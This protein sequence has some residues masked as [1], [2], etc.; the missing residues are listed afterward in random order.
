MTTT[1]EQAKSKIEVSALGLAIQQSSAIVLLTD[2]NGTI[3]YVNPAFERFYG[4]EKESV[5]GENP[6]VLKS[7]EHHQIFYKKMW[8]TITHGKSWS[9]E[10][11][12][13]RKDHSLVHVLATISPIIDDNG[14]IQYFLGVQHDISERVQ[15]DRDERDIILNIS[16]TMR[17][18]NTRDQLASII[19]N[20][21]C[22][23]L[24]MDAAIVGLREDIGHEEQPLE[25]MRIRIISAAGELA[26]CADKQLSVSKEHIL[27]SILQTGRIYTSSNV[28]ENSRIFHAHE[29]DKIRAAVCLPLTVEGQHIGVLCV[30]NTM[31]ISQRDINTLT[32]LSAMIANA[33]YRQTLHEDLEAQMEALKTAQ[34]QI[35]HAEKLAAMGTLVAGV[36]HELNN[37][38]TSIILYAQMALQHVTDIHLRRDLVQ[39]EQLAF[40]MGKVVRGMLDFVHPDSGNKTYITFSEIIDDVLALLMHEIRLQNITVNVDFSSDLPPIY[41]NKSQLEQVFVNLL[42][43]A[44]QA[45]KGYTDHPKIT[46]RATLDALQDKKKPY[47]HVVFQNNGPHI[48]DTALS[49]IFEPFFTTKR[50]GE[51]T[52]LGLS[53]SYSIIELHGGR[54]WVE[55]IDGSAGV[56]FH[57]HLPVIDD[58]NGLYQTKKPT[59]VTTEPNGNAP[60][61]H[62]LLVD[63]EPSILEV[64]ARI[65]S[66]QGYQVDTAQ[67]S[68]NALE[69]I[70]KGDYD[71]VLCDIQMPD[72]NGV[73]LYYRIQETRP[74][75]LSR[76]IFI[77]GDSVDERT[78]EFIRSVPNRLVN[79]PLG[80]NDL[81]KI[82]SEAVN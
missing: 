1:S 68:T 60:S 7:G 66:K 10:L 55:N 3:L 11:I 36:A 58:R 12:N 81:I 40:R 74:D 28:H 70:Q 6:R 52:G 8:D 23:L 76:L 14:H 67:D 80:I 19:T 38:L 33:L 64:F 17:T 4:Y 69:H 73:E 34:K 48:P 63:D 47:I 54:I 32:A 56:R 35:I 22:D 42:M 45:M 20:Q 62:I 26:T 2:P 27:F 18:A 79:K 82:V 30:G 39:I 51:G 29:C 15:R 37:P 46:I 53:I 21:I 49:H 77:S 9:G 72:M 25:N 5:L 24:G 71:L 41:A 65:L 75:M 78:Q 43:N 31:Q 13:Q 61:A 59:R 57:I 50:R 16:R 44:F